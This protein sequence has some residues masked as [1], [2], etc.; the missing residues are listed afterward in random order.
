MKLDQFL[1]MAEITGLDKKIDDRTKK[2]N[3]AVRDFLMTA[4]ANGNINDEDIQAVIFEDNGL[5]DITEK[6]CEYIRKEVERQL[7]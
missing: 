7:Y 5:I 6:E 4:K 3:A 2:L 1:L